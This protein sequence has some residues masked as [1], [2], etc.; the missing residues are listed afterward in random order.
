MFQQ[1]QEIYHLVEPLSQLQPFYKMD[2]VCAQIFV[3]AIALALFRTRQIIYDYD[4]WIKISI[5]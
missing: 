3:T 4:S 2:D 1:F 5:Y